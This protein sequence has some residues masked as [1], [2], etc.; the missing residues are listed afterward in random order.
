MVEPQHPEHG[1]HER[2][3]EV[4]DAEKRPD[5]VGGEQLGVEHAERADHQ[6][7]EHFE[8]DGDPR[9]QIPALALA[10]QRD[11]GE[12]VDDTGQRRQQVGDRGLVEFGDDLHDR[13]RGGPESQDAVHDNEHT[14]DADGA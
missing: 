7:A 1:K 3:E 13:A 10:E 4:S 9:R 11:G 2:D 8:R 5:G 6:H 12:D 14:A